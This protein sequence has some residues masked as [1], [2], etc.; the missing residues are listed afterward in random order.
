VPDRAPSP[1]TDQ[2][3]V[4]QVDAGCRASALETRE[5]GGFGLGQ[6]LAEALPNHPDNDPGDAG[7]SSDGQYE[8]DHAGHGGGRR[9]IDRDGEEQAVLGIA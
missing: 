9:S 8:V 6:V 3:S 2:Q 1:G 7:G 4:E 5:R